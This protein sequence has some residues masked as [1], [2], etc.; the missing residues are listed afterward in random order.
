MFRGCYEHTIDDKGRLSIPV[1]FR[2]ALET[3]FTP[4]FILTR[5]RD[6]LVAY[7]SDEW[8]VLEERMSS[9]PSF[10]TKVQMFRRFFSIRI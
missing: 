2:E 4:P 10:D 7:P 6:C 5:Q 1:K 9:L 8:R 3:T